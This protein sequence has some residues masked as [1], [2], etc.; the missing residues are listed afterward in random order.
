[1][2]TVNALVVLGLVVGFVSSLGI[3]AL[4]GL[5]R[6]VDAFYGALMLPNLFMALCVDYLG[7]N[8]LPAFAR[9]RKQS[10]DL[11][12]ELA[13]S[14]VTIVGL[15]SAAVALL[16]VL[17]SPMIFRALLPGFKA[18]D[19]AIVVHDFA[20]MSPSIALMAVTSFHVYVCQ[21]DDKYVRIMAAQTALPAANL[22]AIFLLGPFIGVV[23]LPVGYTLG[24]LISFVLMARCADYRYRPRIAFRREW[25]GKIFTNSALVVGTGLIGRIRPMIATYLASQLGGGAIAS[26]AFA[27]KLV[28]PVERTAFTGIR[29][30]M[31][32]RTARLN[33]EQRSNEIGALYSLG[34]RASFL[35]LA[36]AIWW[37]ALY[38]P[39]IVQLL[40]QRGAFD[41]RMTHI[42][43]L[44]LAAL[45]PSIPLVGAR[46]LLSNAFYALD[47]SLIP[48]LLMPLG[49]VIY[50][51]MAP[52]ISAAYGVP[53]IAASG[54]I[55]A[56]VTFFLLLGLLGRQF[57]R[58]RA[59]MLAAQL[60][61]YAAMAGAV[62]GFSAAAVGQLPI[63]PIWQ[64]GTGGVLG[65]LLYL[66]A[67]LAAR[68]RTLRE[69]FEYVR[70]ARRPAIGPLAVSR[71]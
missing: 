27:S 14:M 38:S 55:V 12:S 39:V 23:S 42:V 62:F 32:S 22:A 34:L 5:T 63:P 10:F 25:E 26:L 17:L 65:G 71:E 66:A 16:L 18:S 3:A 13:S 60:I 44:T 1:M 15:L 35:L 28:D 54:S 30:L 37:I 57:R 20:I 51:A 40:F 47:R 29:M 24:N 7:K 64:A 31:F 43:A 11:A 56:A 67:L 33:L 46:T 49:T 8:F 52:G 50:L 4:F 53:G 70:R 58:I 36:P 41:A 21:H 6:R 48:A 19:I 2:L 61:G 9:A 45:V 68:N 59:A 69:I